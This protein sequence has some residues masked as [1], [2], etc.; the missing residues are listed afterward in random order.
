MQKK[1]RFAIYGG[2]F[3]PPH[4]GHIEIAKRVLE[5]KGVDKLII[6]PA[7]LNPFKSSSYVDAKKRLEWVKRTFNLK[8]VIISSYEIEQNRPV[9]TVETLKAL[10][11]KYNIKYIVIG[12][13]NLKSIDR[14]KDFDYLNSHYTWIV[15]TRANQNLNL[16]P[17]ND[18][19][20]LNIDVNVSSTDIRNGK[21]LEFVNKQILP[22]VILEYNIDKKERLQ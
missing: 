13:D 12:A 9:F 11:K 16:S 1:D 21:K 5:L 15:A 22:E 19:I 14:W 17:L 2:S 7:F 4:L 8:N 18:Y 10:G 3:D 20:I 6:V